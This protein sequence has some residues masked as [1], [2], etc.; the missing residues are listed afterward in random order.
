MVAEISKGR[1]SWGVR[2]SFANQT[3]NSDC[4]NMSYFG[5]VVVDCISLAKRLFH[6]EFSFVKR[7]A[8]QAAHSLARAIDSMAVSGRW[9]HVPRLLF[10]IFC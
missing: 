4:I 3:L 10:M 8:N 7:R 2:F 9:E 5:S 6:C 1:Y